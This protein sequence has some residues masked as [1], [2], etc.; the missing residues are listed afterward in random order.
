ML[1][2]VRK[3]Y[4]CP[5]LAR[6]RDTHKLRLRIFGTSIE[7]FRLFEIYGCPVFAVQL[8]IYGCPEFRR[9]FRVQRLTIRQMSLQ[10]PLQAVNGQPHNRREP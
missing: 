10:L 1:Q 9:E 8:Q 5:K 7:R 4:G 3:F 6:I 2:A